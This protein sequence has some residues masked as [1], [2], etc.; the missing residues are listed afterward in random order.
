MAIPQT[1]SVPTA[2][3]ETSPPAPRVTISVAEAAVLAATALVALLAAAGLVLANAGRYSLPAALALAALA[4]AGVGV[5]ALRADRRPRLVIDRGE[6]AALAGVGLVSAVLFLPGFSYGVG[7]DPGLYVSHAIA[8]ARTGSASYDDPVLDRSRVPRVEVTPEDTVGRFPGVWI[9]DRDPGGVV[10][11]F[12]HLWPALLASAFTAGGYTGLANLTPLCALLAVLLVVLATRRAFG[13]LTGVL[14]GLLL[15]TNM[16]QVWQAKYPSGEILAQLLVSGALLGVMVAIQTGWR[17]AAGLAGLLVGVTYLARPDGLL[18]ILLALGVGC[19][20]VVTR[21]FDSRAGWFAAGLAIMLPYGAYQAYGIAR[22]Y[23]L[24]N[25][26]PDLPVVL[27]V[28][29][30]ALAAAV[31]VR[32]A[33]PAAGRWASRLLEDRRAQLWAGSAVVGVAAL[34]L[35]LGFLRPWLFGP[36]YGA[37]AGRPIRTYDEV[38]LLRLAYFFTLPGF[39]LALAGLAV[40]ALRRWRAAA[41]A[42][43]LPALC[44]LPLYAYRAQVSPRLM[45]W[46]RR[47]V[48]VVLPGLAVLMAVALGAGLVLAAGSGGRLRWPVRAGAAVATLALL[49]VFTGQ[50]LPLRQHREHGGSFETTQRIAAAAGGR[51]GVFLWEQP[52]AVAYLFGSAVWLQQDQVSALLPRRPDPDY[53]R[54]FV[55][56]FPGQPV[57]VVTRG[58]GLPQGYASLALRPVDRV[59]YVLP[60][61]EETYMRRPASATGVPLRFSIWRVG[62]GAGSG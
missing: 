53:V 44:L 6:L 56:G 8:M 34:L 35:N 55:R 15:A 32:R 2:A 59:S 5:V 46:T 61:W 50:S 37:F 22:R 7:K 48:P 23:T 43:V 45:W 40:V 42:L 11:Q 29:V 20:L 17:P 19:V 33:A 24:A 1:E 3:G 41:W 10:L 13:L 51:Q 57:F 14:A 21:R 30:G 52:S 31:L 60:V 12:Y 62:T 26:V 36:V 54:S 49:A 38:T 39:G 28:I 58:H 47:F 27:A 16:M 9:A 25:H 18:L 4:A